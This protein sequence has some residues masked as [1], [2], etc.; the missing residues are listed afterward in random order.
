MEVTEKKIQARDYEQDNM[1]PD[2]GFLQRRECKT[3]ARII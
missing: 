2:T 3:G 1:E